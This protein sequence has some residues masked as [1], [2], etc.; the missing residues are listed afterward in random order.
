MNILYID[1][2]QGT[3]GATKSLLD[4]LRYLDETMFTPIL[5]CQREGTFSQSFVNE[6]VIVLDQRV[7]LVQAMMFDP[8]SGVRCANTL[9]REFMCTVLN[10]IRGRFHIHLQIC[11]K[12]FSI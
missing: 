2:T 4:M 9:L 11:S 6:G 5:L 12:L 7:K 8:F 10:K 3:G 1:Q